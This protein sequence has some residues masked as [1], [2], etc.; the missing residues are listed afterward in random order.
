MGCHHCTVV[1]DGSKEKFDDLLQLLHF[2]P[3]VHHSFYI[4]LKASNVDSD[5][6]ES[7]DSDTA[8]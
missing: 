4:H 8:D 2:I 6:N 7:E 5:I 3:P 1:Y